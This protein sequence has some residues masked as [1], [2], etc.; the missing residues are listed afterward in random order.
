M[1]VYLYI[2][3][4]SEFMGLDVRSETVSF[5]YVRKGPM[6]EKEANDLLWDYPHAILSVENV[7]EDNG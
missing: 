4:L 3:Q 7:G 1:N 5:R 2:P 6:T